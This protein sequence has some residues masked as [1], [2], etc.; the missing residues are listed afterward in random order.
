MCIN[1][2]H[3]AHNKKRKIHTEIHAKIYVFFSV[4]TC[5]RKKLITIGWAST[6]YRPMYARRDARNMQIGEVKRCSPNACV[7]PYTSGTGCR[8]CTVHV[9]YFRRI[10]RQLSLRDT[11]AAGLEPWPDARAARHDSPSSPKHSRRPG[12]WCIIRQADPKTK[13]MIKTMITKQIHE[14]NSSKKFNGS[15]KLVAKISVQNKD[16]H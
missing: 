2:Y 4:Y 10:I 16:T 1:V 11:S 9:M 8:V 7:R 14:C 15:N 13:P 12:L 5:R 6:C 3:R